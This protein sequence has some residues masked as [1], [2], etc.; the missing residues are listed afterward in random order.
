MAQLSKFFLTGDF[1]DWPLDQSTVCE[2]VRVRIVRAHKDPKTHYRELRVRSRVVKAMANLY[3]ERYVQD[4]GRR[5]NVLKLMKVPTAGHGQRHGKP[6]MKAQLQQHIE[7]RVQEE[8]P[9]SEFGGA[10]GA[11]LKQIQDMLEAIDMESCATS[12]FDMKQATMPDMAASGNNSFQG[13]RLGLLSTKAQ[14]QSQQCLT[15]QA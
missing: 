2:I 3:M 6:S 15:K 7:A 14:S 5:F 13:I 10:D 4:L 8:Y 11:I 12:G 9:D 1:R